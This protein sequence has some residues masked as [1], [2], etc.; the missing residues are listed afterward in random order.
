[1]QLLPPRALVWILLL[2]CVIAFIVPQEIPALQQAPRTSGA[3][4][5]SPRAHCERLR[6]ASKQAGKRVGLR[7]FTC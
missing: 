7:M 5:G 1:M 4:R 2:S 3:Y 6:L